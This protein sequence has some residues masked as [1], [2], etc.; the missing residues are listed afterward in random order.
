MRSRTRRRSISSLRLARSPAAD[1]AGQARHGRVPLPTRRGSMYFSWA[2]STWSLPSRD[3]ARWA[4]MSRISWVRSMTLSAIWSV[5]E[6]IWDGF[7]SWSKTM[8][9]AASW[10]A[11]MASSWSLP[12]PMRK[13]WSTCSRVLDDGVDD[14]DAARARQLPQLRH[15]LLVRRRESRRDADQERPVARVAGRS[16]PLTTRSSSLLDGLDHRQ[17]VDVECGRWQRRQQPVREAFGRCRAARAPRGPRAGSRRRPI[18]DGGH[19]VQPQQRQVGQVV[20][21]RGAR[22][23]D[24]CECSAG[25]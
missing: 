10:R 24:G 13:R 3:R 22:R 6:R 11:W 16:G 8:I 25:R 21:G 14:L 1:A 2:S 20:L 4:K 7:S 18:A 23:S 19:E 5:M 12:V 9:V 15:G 17:A